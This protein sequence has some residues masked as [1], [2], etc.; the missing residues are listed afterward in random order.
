MHIHCKAL[1]LFW[2]VHLLCCRRGSLRFPIVLKGHF[3]VIFTCRHSMATGAEPAELFTNSPLEKVESERSSPSS[4][5]KSFAS[6]TTLHGLRYAVQ[7]G[8]SIPRRSI[9]L[10]FLCAAAGAYTYN[11]TL[12]I[13]RFVSRPTKTVITQETPTD[14]LKF[15]AVTI[16]NLN[17]FMKTK[18]DMKDEEENFV[19]MGLNISGCSETREVRG[20]LTCGQALLCAYDDYGPC[21]SRWLRHYNSPEDTQRS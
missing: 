12:S 14:G 2:D 1:N 7:N 9:W 21:L 18:I 11:S 3:L 6:N 20:N 5:W 8:L 19:K 13:K 10:L 16:C 15:P 4:E 17:K